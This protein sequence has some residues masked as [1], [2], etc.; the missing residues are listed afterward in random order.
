MIRRWFIS[1]FEN[2]GWGHKP[3]NSAS[4]LPLGFSPSLPPSLSPY[5]CRIKS[6][7]V[8]TS[9]SANWPRLANQNI[10]EDTIK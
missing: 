4:L 2:A 6:Q 5:I 9:H 10:H 7:Q 1:G 3:R 8:A